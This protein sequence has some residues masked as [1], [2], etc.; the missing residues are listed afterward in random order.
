MSSVPSQMAGTAR[1]PAGFGLRLPVLLALGALMMLA[2]LGGLGLGPVRIPL[3]E[4]LAAIGQWLGLAAAADASLQTN[5]ILFAIRLPR[6]VLAVAVGAA[7]GCAG[8]AMQGLF[9]NPLADP[10]LIGV[11]SGAALAAVTT[12]V[13]GHNVLHMLD[14]G[15]RPWVLPLAAFCGGLVATLVVLRLGMRNGQASVATLLLAGVAINALCG[16]GIGLLTFMADDLQLRALVFWTM[17]SLGAATWRSILPALPLIV[18]PAVVICGFARRLD[19]FALGEREAGH[20]GIDVERMKITLAL[21]V[22]V[23][24]GAAVSVCGIIGFVGLV[25]PHL[26]RLA[27]GPGHRLVLPGSALLGGAVLALADIAARMVVAPA[28]LP[29]GVVTSLVGG[30]FFL[31][32]LIRQPRGRLS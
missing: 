11:S 27:F 1:R 2:F 6:V 8:A 26:L 21:L 22:A 30:P 12:I 5:Q 29:I 3:T 15:T 13:L 31:W 23:A 7:L 9:R 32:L 19:A 20:L 17:G 16:A 24:T 18:L 10:G 28:E 25:V 14:P 4:L